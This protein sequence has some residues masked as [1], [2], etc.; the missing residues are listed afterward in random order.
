MSNRIMLS[1]L[2]LLSALFL[3]AACESEGNPLGD[4]EWRL[5][6]LGDAESP[7]AVV[8]E[9]DVEF[10]ATEIGLW[11][12]CNSCAGEYSLQRANLSI[13]DLGCTEAGCRT[14]TQFHQEQRI[15][16]VLATIERFEVSGSRLT[17]YGADGEVLLFE[18]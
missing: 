2:L 9:P 16:R 17:L 5:V 12:G 13:G 7:D 1:V 14:M 10:S 8:G 4:T 18:R 3:S 15:Q 11:T 6:G